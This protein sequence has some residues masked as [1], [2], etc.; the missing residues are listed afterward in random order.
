MAD[1][2]NLVNTAYI[3]IGSNLGDA[4]ANVRAAIS[5]L[6]KIG[7]LC[8]CS[9][10]Y[11]TKP[12]G[13]VDQPDFINAAAAIETSDSPR[14]L[15]EKLKTIEINMGR[16]PTSIHWGPRLIDLD[17]LTFGNLQLSESDLII[18]HPSMLERA[19]VLAPLADI[20]NSYAAAYQNLPESLR[21]QVKRL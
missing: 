10:L 20:D 21:L 12:W 7:R 4:I 17:I 2:S 1:Q 19:F 11:L 16:Q 18:P 8:G 6:S 5:E 13:Y 14:Q 3:G 15:L 9:S